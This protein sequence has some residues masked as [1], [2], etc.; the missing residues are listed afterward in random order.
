MNS[1]ARFFSSRAI[2][3]FALG[4]TIVLGIAWLMESLFF[5]FYHFQDWQRPKER[6]MR[7]FLESGYA[8]RPAGLLLLFWGSIIA[9]GHALVHFKLHRWFIWSSVVIAALLILWPMVRVVVYYYMRLEVTFELAIYGLQEIRGL[10]FATAPAALGL[11]LTIPACFL[12]LWA[13]LVA[14]A[15]LFQKKVQPRISP[16]P[17]GFR[18]AFAIVPALLLSSGP[19]LAAFAPTLDHQRIARP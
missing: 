10:I 12:F 11:D 15:L 7:Y 18:P 13:L 2:V 5:A 4:I 19:L 6:L 1:T 8:L 14:W 3:L 16:E 17:Y 9:A